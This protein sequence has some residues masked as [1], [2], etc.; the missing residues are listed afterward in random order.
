MKT[1]QQSSW[2]TR[3]PLGKA[4]HVGIEDPADAVTAEARNRDDDAVCLVQKIGQRVPKPEKIRAVVAGVRRQSDL[5]PG[6]FAVEVGDPVAATSKQLPHAGYGDRQDARP[7]GIVQRQDCVEVALLCRA[8]SRTL[9]LWRS[10]L[11]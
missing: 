11:R 10:C 6:Q 7:G 5:E 2:K 9:R 1:S 4:E 3:A 8:K